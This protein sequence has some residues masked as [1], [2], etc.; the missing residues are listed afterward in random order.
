[1]IAKATLPE[2]VDAEPGL[3]AESTTVAVQVEVAPKVTVEGTHETV[4]VVSRKFTVTMTAALVL[5]EWAV[6]E[7]EGE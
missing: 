7:V 6:S 1:V 5:A 4:L 2:G 3:V